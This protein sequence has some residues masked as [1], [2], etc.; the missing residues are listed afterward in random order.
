MLDYDPFS[1][2]AM[3][4]PHPIYRRLRV[5]SPVHPLADYDGFA[6]ARFE[7]VW[8]VIG[9]RESFSIVQGPVYVREQITRPAD[10]DALDPAS[11]VMAFAS[12]DPP[13]HTE[14]RAVMSRHFRPRTVA[15]FEAEARALARARLDELLPNGRLDVARDYASPVS[16]RVACRVLGL[17][18]HD[19]DE[20]VRLV[21]RSNERGA[22]APGQTQ[23]GAAA[24]LRLHACIQ[25]VVR[26]HRAAGPE[27]GRSLVDT[28]LCAELAGGKLDDAQVATHTLTLLVGG[29]ET[30]P[31]ILAGGVRELSCLPG[32]RAALAADPSLAAGAFEEM[33]RHQGVLQHVGRIALRDLQI[34]GTRVRRG[35][36]LFALL[37]SANRDE[38]EFE[39]PDAFDIRRR[40]ERHVAFGQGPHHCVGIHVARLEGRILIEEL[41]ARV[42]DYAVLE[43]EAARPPSEFQIGYTC[44][45]IEF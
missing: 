43:D 7:D 39:D 17:S 25:D 9:D 33:V 20:L 14:I 44:L 34:R 8:R 29:T 35:Q 45:P 42:P 37:Q 11:P 30:M 32:Q 5:E 26:E 13:A 19:A 31:K 4:D 15:R 6:L 24:H 3:T 16:I 10:L 1:L 18:T 27:D 21:N 40:P 28:L 2:E 36:R 12:W 23:D 22:G 41:L 38:F